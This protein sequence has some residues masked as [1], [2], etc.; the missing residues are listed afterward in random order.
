M[1]RPRAD[2]V[3]PPRCLGVEGGDYPE[4]RP[5]QPHGRDDDASW[6]V[7]DRHSD[8]EP[9]P[10]PPT[11]WPGVGQ[12]EVTLIAPSSHRTCSTLKRGLQTFR[13]L[14]ACPGCFR[15][16]RSPGGACTRWK[17][18]AL[19]RRTRKPAIAPPAIGINQIRAV[20]VGAL[21]SGPPRAVFP[22]LKPDNILVQ[23]RKSAI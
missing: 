21:G 12:T 9:L 17:S 4:C 18:A 16:E 14:H 1:T 19:S 2:G 13:H 3:P 5:G 20:P 11:G 8:A 7:E 23:F 15:L 10:L 6:R 22:C